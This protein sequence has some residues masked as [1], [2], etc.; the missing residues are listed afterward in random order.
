MPS[1]PRGR[2][3]LQELATSQTKFDVDIRGS[4]KFGVRS[5]TFFR[6]VS[7]SAWVSY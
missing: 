5:G 2:T 6:A 4:F 1:V 7:R 3:P